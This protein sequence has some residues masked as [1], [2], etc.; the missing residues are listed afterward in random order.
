MFPFRQIIHNGVSSVENRRSV[1]HEGR[2]EPGFLLGIRGVIL[3]VL[4]PLRTSESIARI[5][6]LWSRV[7]TKLMTY[8]DLR[9][10]TRIRPL[11]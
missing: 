2:H 3:E 6:P 9:L 11:R 10:M 8:A 4:I 7:S 1:S 5:Y